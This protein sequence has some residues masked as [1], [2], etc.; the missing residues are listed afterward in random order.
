M[1]CSKLAFYTSVDNLWMFTLFYT[2]TKWEELISKTRH[3]NSTRGKHSKGRWAT[4]KTHLVRAAHKYPLS[5]EWARSIFA[6]SILM[7][8]IPSQRTVKS[9]DLITQEAETALYF[10]CTVKWATWA[11]SCSHQYYRTKVCRSEV[12]LRFPVNHHHS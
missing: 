4:A 10:L 1:R 12:T 3:K 6:T 9:V 8:T 2:G 11:Q 5:K 7:F